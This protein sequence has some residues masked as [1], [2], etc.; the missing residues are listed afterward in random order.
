MISMAKGTPASSNFFFVEER[1]LFYVELEVT[2][3]YIH[4]LKPWK[5]N[6]NF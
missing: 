5:S 4:D 1:F 6:N 2:G 3:Y